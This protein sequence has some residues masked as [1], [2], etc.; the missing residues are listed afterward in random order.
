[1]GMSLKQSNKNRKKYNTTEGDV[2]RGENMMVFKNIAPTCTCDY[3]AWFTG[4]MFFL[5]LTIMFI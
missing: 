2:V 4:T 3:T 5:L 1:M